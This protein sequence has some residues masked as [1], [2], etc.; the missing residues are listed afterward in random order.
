MLRDPEPGNHSISSAASKPAL[1]FIQPSIKLKL[2]VSS[3]VHSRREL[4]SSTKLRLLPSLRIGGN[5]PLLPHT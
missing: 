3:R 1:V 2:S 5:V 4:M